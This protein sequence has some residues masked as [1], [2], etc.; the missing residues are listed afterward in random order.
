MIKKTYS[1]TL[2]TYNT[3][4][5]KGFWNKC[6]LT[7]ITTNQTNKQTI[8]QQQN[9]TLMT[10]V[11]KQEYKGLFMLYAVLSIRDMVWGGNTHGWKIRQNARS[12]PL[13][14]QTNKWTNR[15][16]I[17]TRKK[18][19]KNTK[20]TI[21]QFLFLFISFLE[22]EFTICLPWQHSIFALNKTI[23]FS[24]PLFYVLPT[25]FRH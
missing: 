9:D 5:L 20:S 22:N 3:E 15:K 21:F 8:K 10:Q 19:K 14:K 13:R 16:S 18:K 1:V 4:L 23:L 24:M 25:V 2:H 12:P 11:N 7:N 6:V 17:Q